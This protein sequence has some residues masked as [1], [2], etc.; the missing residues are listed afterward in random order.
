MSHYRRL[1]LDLLS[2][3]QAKTEHTDL[4]NEIKKHDRAY[5][6]NDAPLITD[7]EYDKLRKRLEALESLYPNFI[8]DQSPSQT[9]GFDMADDSQEASDSDKSSEKPSEKSFGKSSG[10]SKVTHLIPMLSLSNAFTSDDLHDFSVRMCRYLGIPLDTDLETIAEP[11]I[12]G[13]SC[14][15]V[16]EKGELLTAATR[17]DGYIGENITENVKTIGDIPVS[18]QHFENGPQ[19]IEVRGEIYMGKDDFFAL[20]ERQKELGKPVFANPRN[21]AAGSVR[22]LDAT[23]TKSR[24]LRFFAYGFGGSDGNGDDLSFQTHKDRLD[25]L[26]KWGFSVNPRI[27]M[28]QNAAEMWAYHEALE[29]E[30]GT[31]DY[32]IDGTV[33]KINEL[34]F[35]QRLGHVARSPRYAIAAKFPP[36]KGVTILNDISIQVGRTGVLTPVAE[37]SPVNIGGVLVSRA[38][39]HNA[40]EIERKDVRIQDTVIVQRAGDVIPQIIGVKLSQDQPRQKPFSF[41]QNCP[42]CG[43]KVHKKSCEV[44]IRCE[45]GLKCPAQAVLRLQHFVSKGAFDIDGFGAKHVKLF[46][47]KKWIA[48]PEDIF[49]LREIS[50]SSENPLHKWEGWGQKSASN[51]FQA[52]D[53]K[54]TISLDRFIYALGIRQIGQTTAKLLARHYTKFQNWFDHMVAASDDRE[55]QAYDDLVNMN[56]IGQDMAEDLLLFFTD[57]HNRDLLQAL[58][59]RHITIQDFETTKIMDNPFKGKSIVFTGSLITM[60]RSEAKSKAEAMGAK[61]VGSVSK[62]TDFVV[63]GQDAGSKAKKAQELQLKQL[64]E[65]EWV[66]ACKTHH[67]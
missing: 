8:S 67:S 21:A 38:T 66:E 63:I 29:M 33:F 58:V 28:C 19:T 51:L 13:L 39:L 1:P 57:Y 47:Y 44:A 16:Y 26:K 4:V 42:S 49:R 34:A 2:K 24:P 32:D 3:E 20:N 53:E 65:T 10:F 64:T 5:Y 52:I 36:E 7:A 9:V 46:F 45:N 40:D 6:Q 43:S 61:V 25:T 27:K 18:L 59:S 55:S 56:G 48:S 11:K 12:D 15:L 31:L 35:E 54:R 30:R 37:L 14:S 60:G 22:Q 62:K 50:Q 23:I 17:G 41:P